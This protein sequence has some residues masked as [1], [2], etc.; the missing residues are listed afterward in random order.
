MIINNK[1][2]YKYFLSCFFYFFIINFIKI[3]TYFSVFQN[4]CFS[5]KTFLFQYSIIFFVGY[6][7]LDKHFTVL[8]FSRLNSRKS[9]LLNH[10]VAH[11]LLAFIILNIFFFSVVVC[12]ILSD[13]PSSRQIMIVLFENYLRF[14]E[15]TITASVF[16]L[17]IQYLCFKRMNSLSH[18]I[19]FLFMALEILFVA[20]ESD[21][22]FGIK[23][24]FLF[25]WIF[26]SNVFTSFGIITTIN[27]LLLF[28]LFK[29]F[30][31]VDLI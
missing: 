9:L 20:P 22:L 3:Y 19:T 4:V 31:K 15:G 17:T 7:F 12:L 28:L 29:K 27:M 25:S 13:F 24:N 5:D 10:I 18:I 6:S 14:L 2:F 21:S 30:K 8:S 1:L 16:S 23:L 26:H 11:I